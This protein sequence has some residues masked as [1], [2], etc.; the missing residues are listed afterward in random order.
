M[1][2]YEEMLE[3]GISHI[4]QVIAENYVSGRRSVVHENYISCCGIEFWH[5]HHKS[6][7]VQ[8]ISAFIA[9]LMLSPFSLVF[10]LIY[11]GYIDG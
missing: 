6:F 11:L 3:V 10:S 2:R 7:P 1:A 8:N 9:M 5:L 4:K